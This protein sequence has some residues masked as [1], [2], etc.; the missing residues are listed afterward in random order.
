[1]HSLTHMELHS[2]VEEEIINPDIHQEINSLLK[3]RNKW[4][5]ISNI[6]ETL[7]NIFILSSTMLSFASGVY[8]DNKSLSFVAGCS[9]VMSISLLK[10]SSYSSSESTERSKLLNDLLARCNVMPMPV[11]YGITPVNT[12]SNIV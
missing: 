1:M 7:G 2:T 11:Q 8:S 12:P 4:K 5:R 6:T 3:S 9:N 10:F